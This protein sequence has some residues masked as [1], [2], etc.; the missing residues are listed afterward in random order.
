M[1]QRDE[2]RCAFLGR[3]GRC[4]ATGKLEFH[5]KVPFAEGGGATEA[6]TELRC[7]VHN[8]LEAS[9][10]FGDDVNS[11]RVRMDANSGTREQWN[12]GRTK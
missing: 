5:H 7:R 3:D 2:G 4:G 10:W 9:R 8:L 1:W 6:N 11:C 12:L